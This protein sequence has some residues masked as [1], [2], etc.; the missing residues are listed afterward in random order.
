MLLTVPGAVTLSLSPESTAAAPSQ[1]MCRD[2]LSLL[3]SA[4]PLSH[5]HCLSRP[6]PALTPLSAAACPVSVTRGTGHLAHRPHCPSPGHTGPPAAPGAPVP[7]PLPTA[8]CPIPPVTCHPEPRAGHASPP[9]HAKG[10][11]HLSLS[12]AW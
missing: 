4:T 1:R 5:P 7:G 8:R 12:P 9:P 2:L 11:P 10:P 6:P 3:L